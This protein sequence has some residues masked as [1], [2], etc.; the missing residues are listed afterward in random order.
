MPKYL[1]Q[2]G[3]KAYGGFKTR[4][5]KGHL[6]S[7]KTRKSVSIARGNKPSWN[8]GKHFSE[9]SKRKMSIF[10]KKRFQKKE[11]HPRWLGGISFEPYSLDWTETLR[12]AIRERDNY[13]CKLCGKLQGDRVHSV[14]HID[15]GKKNCN[16]N[17]LI[18]LCVSC[19]SK[20][21]KNRNYWT[22][23]FNNKYAI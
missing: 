20:V 16:P 2:K 17:N 19:N 21:N 6:V 4:F 11:N 8:K 5:K 3:H 7:E 13:I 1:F 22:N 10:Q 9:E 18:T 15:Y 23:Y 12:R 14:H